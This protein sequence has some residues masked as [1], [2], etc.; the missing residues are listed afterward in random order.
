MTLFRPPAPRPCSSCP[1][2]LDAPSGLWHPLEYD[3]LPKYDQPTP[4]QPPGVFL[5]HQ[6]G[7]RVCA[8]W[9]GCHDMVHALALRLATTLGS[10]T[11]DAVEAVLD[12]VS[13]VPLFPTG[14]A[15]AEH[16]RRDM[17]APGADARRA[18]AQ[19]LRQRDDLIDLSPLRSR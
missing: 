8:G 14:A 1:Y 6:P 3:L 13:P 19:L 16:G 11:P 4:F 15:A 9:A 12:Y 7:N 17:Y 2:R 5:C 18:A 10:M